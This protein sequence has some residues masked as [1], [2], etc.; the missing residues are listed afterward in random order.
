VSLVIPFHKC[1]ARPDESNYEFLLTSHLAAV[2]VGYG[3]ID[4][5]WED[6]LYFLGGLCHDAAKGRRKW[7]ENFI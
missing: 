7:Q 5:C 4:G 6:K 1:K 3:K 2:A